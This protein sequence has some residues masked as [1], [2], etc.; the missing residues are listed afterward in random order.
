MI[1]QKANWLLLDLLWLV[2][3]PVTVCSQSP[4]LFELVRR[5]CLDGPL[6][7]CGNLLSWVCAETDV[8]LPGP[9]GGEQ[10]P[11]QSSLTRSGAPLS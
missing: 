10:M 11:C 2:L 8:Q 9:P 7:V 4:D 1:G 5:R 6:P 3:W